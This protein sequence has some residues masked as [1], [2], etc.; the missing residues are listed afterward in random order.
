M[1][2]LSTTLFYK[3]KENI[4]CIAWKESY[5]AVCLSWKVIHVFREKIGCKDDFG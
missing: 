3:R 2:R 4:M 1:E 5:A